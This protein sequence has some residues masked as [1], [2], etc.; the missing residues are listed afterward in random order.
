MFDDEINAIAATRIAA[1][2]REECYCREQTRR[3]QRQRPPVPQV[4]TD[5]QIKRGLIAEFVRWA[6]RYRIE[7]KTWRYGGIFG[8][9]VRGWDLTS[10]VYMW[11]DPDSRAYINRRLVLVVDQRDSL[12]VIAEDNY[13][14][15]GTK[16]DGID[17]PFHQGATTALLDDMTLQAV[18]EWVAGFVTRDR[19]WGR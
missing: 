2:E 14:P 19:P 13:C 11:G 15:P 9:K 16:V 7:P 10:S 8:S 5:L 12:H 4:P 6:D 1:K 18:K 3:A 17:M